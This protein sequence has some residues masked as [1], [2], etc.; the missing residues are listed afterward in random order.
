MFDE[1]SSKILVVLDND[2]MIELPTLMGFVLC[3]AAG[4]DAVAANED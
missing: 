1:E 2:M 3:F 4:D